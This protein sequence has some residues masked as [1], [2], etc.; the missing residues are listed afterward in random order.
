M[1]IQANFPAL[2]PSLLLDFANTKQ[3]DSRITY[4][5]ASTATFYNGVTT[6]KAE[7][8]LVLY[9]EQFDNAAYSKDNITITANATTSPDGNTTAE[10]MA[11]TATTGLHHLSQDKS[12]VWVAS[13][14]Y[15]LSCYA[16]NVDATYINLVLRGTTGNIANVEFN[17]ST[18]AVNRTNALGTG[19]SVVSSSITSVGNSWYRC[20]AVINTG[21]NV[22]AGTLYIG[23]SDGTTAFDTNGR[24]SYTG[25]SKSIYIWGMQAEQRSAVTA[26]TATTTQAITNYI[27]VLQTA[28]SGVARFDNNPTTGESLGLLIEES[29]T[30]LLTYS[31]GFNTNWATSAMSL[32]A[33]SNVAPDGTLTAYSM[34]PDTSSSAHYINQTGTAVTVTHTISCYAKYNGYR[35]FQIMGASS[36]EQYA[37]FDL[38]GGTIT[39]TGTAVSSSV[40]TSVGNGWYRCS[41]TLSTGAATLVRLLIVPSGTS[42]WNASGLTGNGFSGVFIWGAQLEAGAFATSYIPTV[43]SQVTRAADAAS[44]TGTNFSSWFN[45]SQGTVYADGNTKS[46]TVACLLSVSAAS[47]GVGNGFLLR[48]QTTAIQFGGNNS[49]TSSGSVTTNSNVRS[50]AFYQGL[51]ATSAANGGSVSSITNLD[52]TGVG[53]TTLYI[54]F[55]VGGQIFNG[56]IKKIAYYP[57]AV[58]SA[59]LVALTS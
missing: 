21:T 2:K 55:L 46:N 42:G 44:M 13:S 34:T 26:Y 3:L 19:F 15:V 14:T 36:T 43:A 1:A 25:T 52:F 16:K 59:N 50:A 35:Y 39:A 37:N 40:M 53:T 38:Q 11:E 6:A 48:Q 28:A 41:I 29:R 17:V 4:T 27:P 9:S 54:G 5:R 32:T 45:V 12:N 24:V 30:N 20:V 8:N 31:S 51:N 47:Y 33:T 58:T 23:L 7:E 10:Q 49:A 18:G 56:T 57:L 22:S